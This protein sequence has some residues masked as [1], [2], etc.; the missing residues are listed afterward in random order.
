M[1]TYLRSCQLCKPFKNFSA[2]YGTRR[3]ID[4]FARVL[5]WSQPWARSIQSIQKVYQ[6]VYYTFLFAS[7][8]NKCVWYFLYTFIFLFSL[9]REYAY[10]FYIYIFSLVKRCTILCIAILRN[11]CVCLFDMYFSLPLISAIFFPFYTCIFLFL[12][13]VFFCLLNTHIWLFIFYE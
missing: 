9:T 1:C 13:L 3:F 6:P 2:C 10:L 5:H 11:A 4:M 12:T 8:L 7:L